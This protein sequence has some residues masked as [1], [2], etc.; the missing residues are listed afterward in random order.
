[1]SYLWTFYKTSYYWDKNIINKKNYT[2]Y[3]NIL[4]WKYGRN[5]E[6]LWDKEKSN[7][8]K[9]LGLHQNSKQQNGAIFYKVKEAWIYNLLGSQYVILNHVRLL[10]SSCQSIPAS[11][12]RPCISHTADDLPLPASLAPEASLATA[13]QTLP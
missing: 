12:P 8:K 11:L 10:S 3:R 13:D 5:S 6:S 7:K 1:M 2:Y 9:D 4:K